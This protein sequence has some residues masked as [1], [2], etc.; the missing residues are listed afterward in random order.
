MTSSLRYLV[1]SLAL[2]HAGC[3]GTPPIPE[4]RFYELGA[5]SPELPRSSPVL[6]G[7]LTVE[8]VM[9]DPM[10]GGRAIVYRH[11]GKP[12]ELRRYHYE[13][14]VDDPP[15]M[16][17]RALVSYLAGSGVADV[18]KDGNLRSGTDYR[19]R[20]SL[21]RFEHLVGATPP[22]FEVEMAVTLYSRRADAVLLSKVYHQRQEAREGDM[23]TVA[24]AMQSALDS[25]FHSMATDI[26]SLDIRL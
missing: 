11:N 13:F 21:L 18:V 20:T 6:N 15:A 4:D 19:L 22:A 24:L 16:L 12:L 5:T 2:A 3:T 7:G 8:P 17:R 14:W 26:D 1:L 25:I 23:H 9:T 10:R